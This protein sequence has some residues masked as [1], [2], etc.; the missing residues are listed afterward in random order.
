V[1]TQLPVRESDASSV[2]AAIPVLTSRVHIERAAMPRQAPAPEGA[3]ERSP[4]VLDEKTLDQIR[5]LQRG[6]P[7]LLAKVAEMYLENSTMLLDELRVNLNS[8]NAAGIA[9]AAHAL[10]S[11]SFNVGAKGLGELCAGIEA[12][13]SAGRTDEAKAAWERLYNEHGR[14]VMALEAL[15]AAA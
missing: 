8:K 3:P 6:V 10:K 1:V 4:P 7:N 5:E 9:K 13:G 12:L 11:T 2:V 14:V 15:K